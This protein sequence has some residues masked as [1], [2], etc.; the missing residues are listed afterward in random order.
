MR[1]SLL[2]SLGRPRDALNS[3]AALGFSVGED[4]RYLAPSRLRVGELY[5][6]LG[7]PEQA[8]EQFVRFVTL[9]QDCDPEHSPW[10]RT[11][12]DV[13]FGCAR[14]Q[15][16]ARSVERALARAVSRH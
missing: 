16:L 9:R 6:H 8:I 1:A 15:M 10:S 4:M 11:S 12:A 13:S 2:A 5:E 14:D 3:Y 7:E